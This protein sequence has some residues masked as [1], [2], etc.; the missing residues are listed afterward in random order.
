MAKRDSTP[1]NLFELSEKTGDII[2]AVIG[3]AHKSEQIG[4]GLLGAFPQLESTTFFFQRIL[5]SS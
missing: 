4:L 1:P 3:V 2:L 5:Y